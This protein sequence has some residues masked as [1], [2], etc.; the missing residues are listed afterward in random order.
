MLFFASVE[1]LTTFSLPS[2][3]VVDYVTGFPDGECTLHSW[4]NKPMGF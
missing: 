4:K 2:I 1:T 3:D